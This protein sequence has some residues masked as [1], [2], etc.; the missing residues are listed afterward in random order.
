MIRRPSLLTAALSE[1]ERLLPTGGSVTLK[2]V[3]ASEATLTLD[4]S[5]PAVKIR[6]TS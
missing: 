6:W 1:K 2:M 3:G 5:A 4:E